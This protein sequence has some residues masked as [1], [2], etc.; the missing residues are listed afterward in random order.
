[1]H[2]VCELGANAGQNLEALREVRPELRL[3][4]AEINAQACERMTRVPGVTAVR[5]SIQD[6]AASG[7][8]DLVFTC[9]VLI[10]V[11]PEDL[12]AVYR[13]MVA[14]SSRYLL[15]NEYFNPRPQEIPYRGHAGRLFKRDF[16]AELLELCP[17][18][19]LVDYGFLWKRRHPAW[20]DTT[21][22]LLEK[23][24][25]PSQPEP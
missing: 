17:D 7:R 15:V 10:H 3:T 4:G 23:R 9:G 5:S 14:L 24:P 16:A 8:F 22:F 2:T 20:D 1:M 18:V 13:K 6:F 12:P 11:C 21:W 19:Q 25:P